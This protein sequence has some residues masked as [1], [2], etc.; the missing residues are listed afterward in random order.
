MRPAAIGES[1]LLNET[2]LEELSSIARSIDVAKLLLKFVA[3]FGT[4]Y[5]ESSLIVS[6]ICKIERFLKGV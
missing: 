1:V 4:K 2:S 5:R 3:P 6:K